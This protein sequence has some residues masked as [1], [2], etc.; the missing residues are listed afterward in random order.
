[1][2]IPT[3]ATSFSEASL[4][5]GEGRALS[6]W[7]CFAARRLW[8]RR[9]VLPRRH[10]DFSAGYCAPLCGPFLEWRIPANVNQSSNNKYLG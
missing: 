8:H 3:F 9:I 5:L 7:V 10:M 4:T 6:V 2:D 1:M